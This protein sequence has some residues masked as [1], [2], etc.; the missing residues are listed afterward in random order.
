LLIESAALVAVWSDTE[1]PTKREGMTWGLTVKYLT[2]TTG[3][4]LQATARVLR[5]V[6]RVAY[7]D[8]QVRNPSGSLV[9]QGL[10]SYKLG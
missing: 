8:V 3:E 7:L 10:V 1:L 4:D 6:Q 9:A 2:A 5:R